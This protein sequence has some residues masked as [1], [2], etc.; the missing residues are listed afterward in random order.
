[1]PRDEPA[2]LYVGIKGCVVAIDRDSGDAIWNADLRSAEYV[3]VFWDGSGLFA[4]NS[5]EVWRLDPATGA[6]IWHNEL[7]GF[8]RG[9]VSLASNRSLGA[10]GT[11]ESVEEMRRRD[12]AAADTTVV[13]G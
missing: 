10:S 12:A 8:G 5:G 6:T 3:S 7:K 1:M 2:L 9:L 11:A 13:T 4:A